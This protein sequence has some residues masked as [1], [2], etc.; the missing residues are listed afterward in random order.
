[1]DG[2]FLG[3]AELLLGISLPALG[4]PRPSLFFYLD[5]PILYNL[6]V[7]D[8]LSLGTSL[9]TGIQML[10]PWH[11]LQM[12]SYLG[13][14]V[15]SVT[16]QCIWSSCLASKFSNPG[17]ELPYTQKKNFEKYCCYL[18]KD[19]ICLSKLLPLFKIVH[20]GRVWMLL[21]KIN[22][23]VSFLR[24]CIHHLSM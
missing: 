13:C 15:M 12:Q 2:V 24:L 19:H 4:K 3:L 22:F 14:V 20:W 16:P 21:F 11:L 7:L 17:E 5:L 18:C 8:F 23:I 6:L 9:N 10:C 1:M